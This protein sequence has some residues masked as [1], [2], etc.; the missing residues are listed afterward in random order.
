MSAPELPSDQPNQLGRDAPSGTD[1]NVPSFQGAARPGGP[2]SPLTSD[3][4]HGFQPVHTPPPEPGP[5]WVIALVVVLLVTLLGVLAV[6][7]LTG[8]QAEPSP[9]PS[10]IASAS[11]TAAV[12]LTPAPTAAPTPSALRPTSGPTTTAG[13][14]PAGPARTS[15]P[16]DIAAQIDLVVSQ[17]PP[18]RELEPERDVPYELIT[19][20]QFRADLQDIL[21]EEMDPER[22]AAEE[23]L[24]KR[25]GLLPPEMDLAAALD[26]LYGSQVAAFYRSDTRTFYVIG[27]DQP[28]GA[29][30]RMIVAHEYTHAL[31]DQHFDLEGTRITD[32]SEGD[33][34]L[35]QLAVIEGD[36]TLLMVQWA[37][38]NLSLGELFEMLS[39][40]L[41]P[42][43]QQ[44]LENM[45]PI[46]RRQ[47]EF[48]YSDGFTFVSEIWE[49]GG[50]QAVDAAL[51]EPPPSTEQIMHVDKFR[52]GEQPISVQL[53]DLSGALGAGWGLGY[54][55]TF[56]ELI[57]HVW[58]AGGEEG[59]STLPGLPPALRH[60]EVAEGWGGDRL[61][62]YEGADGGWAIVWESA[63]DSQADAD[64]FATR[65]RELRSRLDGESSVVVV[66]QL[67][68][69]DRVRVLLASDQQVLNSLFGALGN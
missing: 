6:M 9:S 50:W 54:E 14:S 3:T 27:R 20:E 7:L 48:P 28:F 46:L 64:E 38:Q 69:P 12:Q 57:S 22:L 56:G 11:P 44:I 25:L 31:Q 47:L 2:G 10:A 21:A 1:A 52:N 66:P 37:T 40:S 49:E 32:L 63:W 13:A 4:G 58:V 36:A 67:G 51:G 19:R 29:F 59:P 17:V 26:E 34:A 15:L 39:Q 65:A 55:Q 23:R 42:T 41:S 45:P 35:A 53:A 8:G 18:I 5:P 43:D 30:D 16:S 24:L 60:A 68:R 61:Q 33:A 62:M